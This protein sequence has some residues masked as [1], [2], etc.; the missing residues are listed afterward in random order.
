V[1]FKV[2]QTKLF[3]CCLLFP[4]VLFICINFVVQGIVWGELQYSEPPFLP[5]LESQ[6]DIGYFPSASS[7]NLDQFRNFF[8]FFFFFLMILFVVVDISLRVSVAVL[9]TALKRKEKAKRRKE[10]KR[11]GKSLIGVGSHER[12]EK[13]Y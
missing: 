3:E 7:A 11:F 1:V 8:F 13:I 9:A 5:E 10:A 12:K 6:L 4:N 2:H